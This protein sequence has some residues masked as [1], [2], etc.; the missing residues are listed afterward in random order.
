MYM[1]YMIYIIYV[2]IYYNIYIHFIFNV[3][4]HIKVIKVKILSNLIY[5]C[6][7]NVLYY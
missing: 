3:C 4:L 7:Y 1:I 6:V 2:F 5:L